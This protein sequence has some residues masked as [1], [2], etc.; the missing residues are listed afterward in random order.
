[1][2]VLVVLSVLALA[3][4]GGGSGDALSAF[5]PMSNVAPGWTREGEVDTFDTD[6]LFELVNGQAESYFA[7]GFDQVAVGRYVN[8]SGQRLRLELY[9]LASPAD[10]YG[11]FSVSRGGQPVAVG[12]DGD[13]DPGRRLAFWQDRYYGRILAPQ[14]VDEGVLMSFAQAVTGAVPPGG[15]APALVA[16]LP[17]EGLQ[18]LEVRFFRQELS[19]QNWLW[20]GGQNVLGMD[21]KSEGVLATYSLTTTD[22]SG[23]PFQVLLAAYPQPEQAQAA[24]AALRSAE[25]DGLA[26]VEANDTLLAAV[27]GDVDSAAAGRIVEE[28][29]Q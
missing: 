16:K 15:E 13:M 2:A 20:L 17:M 27:F 7:Y 24:V 6:T 14:P 1:M 5:L 28:I 3:A 18:P 25:I 21:N 23:G 11:L 26:A 10:A 9:R 12:N 29:L 22:D 19:I 4:C 8:A